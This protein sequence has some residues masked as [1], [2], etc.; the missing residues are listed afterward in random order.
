MTPGGDRTHLKSR[1]QLIIK[2]HQVGQR[3]YVP[4]DS[5]ITGQ[6]LLVIMVCRVANRPSTSK[7]ELF[8]PVTDHP[9]VFRL[10]MRNNQGYHSAGRNSDLAKKN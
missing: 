6:I 4:P 9:P 5:R 1:Q 10:V 2:Y 8:L 7:Y 3:V